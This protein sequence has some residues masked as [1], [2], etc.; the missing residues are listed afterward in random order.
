MADLMETSRWEPRFA[1]SWI[2]I[3]PAPLSMTEPERWAWFKEYCDKYEY[4]KP[5]KTTLGQH[6]IICDGVETSAANFDDAVDLA[7]AKHKEMNG[8]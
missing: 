7:A 6:V 5:T 2:E 3:Q 1:E 4:V 8:G